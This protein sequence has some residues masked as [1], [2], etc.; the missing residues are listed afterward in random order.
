[1][2]RFSNNKNMKNKNSLNF[3]GYPI[4]WSDLHE[5]NKKIGQLLSLSRLSHLLTLNPEI[6]VLAQKDPS[7]KS[8]LQKTIIEL[9]KRYHF[10]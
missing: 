10:L 7:L 6:M 8:F 9:H 5:I 4:F 3:F 2:I 1:M